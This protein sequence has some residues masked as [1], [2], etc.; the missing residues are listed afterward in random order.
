MRWLLFLSVLAVACARTG[1]ETLDTSP[2]AAPSSSATNQGAGGTAANGGTSG[3]GKGGATSNGGASGRSS[4]GPPSSAAKCA[5]GFGWG[6]A[7]P[8]K[9]PGG[10]VPSTVAVGDLD[11]DCH[12]DIAVNNYGGGVAGLVVDTLRNNGDG[13]FATGTTFSSTVAFS[14]AIGPLASDEN[15]LLVGCLLFPNQGKD[16]FGAAIKYGTSHCGGQDSWRNLA[17]GDFDGDGKLDFAW[18]LSNTAAVYLNRGGGGFLEVDT[19]LSAES[20]HVTTMTSAD[21][22]GDGFA[23]LATAMWGYG[24][25]NRLVL[26]Y[27]KGHG[28]FDPVPLDTGETVPT[29][30]AAG[31]IN[32][33]GSVDLVTTTTHPTAVELR[34]RET[35]RTY[36]AP[37][38]YVASLQ[39]PI[40]L[41]GDINGDGLDDIVIADE[42]GIGL[43]YLLNAGDGVFSDQTFLPIDGSLWNATLGDLNGDGVMDIVAAVAFAESGGYAE[44]WLSQCQPIPH[45]D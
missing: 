2:F 43:S 20:L 17:T 11:G 9:Y 45:P 7:P 38:P 26:L 44:V 36:Y 41:L 10:P 30:I 33:D 23:D 1:L 16:T 19:T 34:F 29:S 24:D 4:C 27:G 14:M 37:V 6:F 15:D 13:S 28:L 18:G 22:D 32:G 12:P 25:P 42:N 31:D 5:P 39:S 8:V 21:L 40:T 3:R 35:D